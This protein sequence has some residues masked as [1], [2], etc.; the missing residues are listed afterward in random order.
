M[1][2]NTEEIYQNGLLADS[3][4]IDFN[5]LYDTAT[6]KRCQIYSRKRCQI[7]FLKPENS[8]ETF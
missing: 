8:S 7:Y 6:R 5:G 3:A 4:Y 1:T 2:A